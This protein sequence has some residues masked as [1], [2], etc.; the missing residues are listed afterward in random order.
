MRI[1]VAGIECDCPAELALGSR[2]IEI[3]RP[4]RSCERGVSFGESIVQLQGL[5]RR[6]LSLGH[7][8]RWCQQ[9]FVETRPIIGIGQAR[10][11]ECEVWV[12]LNRMLE[13]PQRFF[14]ILIARTAQEIAALE[15][16]LVRLGV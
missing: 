2:P 10:K 14:D 16:R 6:R 11:R 4:P 3:E 5:L 7:R 9:P 12:Y 1:R 8:F 13:L 15:I